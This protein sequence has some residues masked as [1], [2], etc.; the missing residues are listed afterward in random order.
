MGNNGPKRA[1]DK[2]T[3]M[4]SDEIRQK[5]GFIGVYADFAIQVLLQLAVQNKRKPR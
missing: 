1:L 3:K 5:F 4:D 2:M